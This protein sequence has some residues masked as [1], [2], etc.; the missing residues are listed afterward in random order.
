MTRRE[1]IQ[2]IR[3]SISPRYIRSVLMDLSVFHRQVASDQIVA[4][5]EKAAALMEEV[6]LKTNLYSFTNVEDYCLK[7]PN[8]MAWSFWQAK[9]GWCEVVGEEGRK[10]ADY[11]SDPLS[12]LRESIS[13]D[14]RNEP[15][16]VIYMDRGTEEENYADMDF[17]GKVVFMKNQGDMAVNV[18]S[19]LSWAVKK[20]GA[21]G[22]I[23]SVVGT[24]PDIRG[25]W[26][27]YD[28][29]AWARA[30]PG[31]F[32]FGITP[33][34]GDRLERTYYEKQKK[35]EK[36][37]IRCFVDSEADPVGTMA[38]A[39]ATIEG[40][41]PEEEVVIFAH[42]CHPRPSVNDNLSGCSA[43]LSAMYALNELI[44]RGILPQP[45]RSIR[46]IVGPEMRG[47]LAEI[48]RKGR[49]NTR[50][51]FNMDMVGTD[52]GNPGAGAVFLSD[53]P[54]AT[55]NI[56]NDV[57]SFCLEEVMKDVHN[58][59]VDWLCT[60]NLTQT[61]FSADSDQDMWND[62][63]LDSPCAYMGQY[64]DPYFHS[65]S[66]DISVIDPTL[67]ARSASV[68]AAFAYIIATLEVDDLPLFMAKGC[69]N[70]TRS[71][72]REEYNGDKAYYATIASH[73]RDYYLGCCD[74]YAGYFDGE[75]KARAEELISAQK[76]NISTVIG[77]VANSILGC[78][79][80]LDDYPCDG[81]DLPEKYQY[82][83][84]RHFIGRIWDLPGFAA[85]VEGGTELL[86][87]YNM[88]HRGFNVNRCD[89]TS[90]F[91]ADGKRTLAECIARTCIDRKESRREEMAE[92]LHDYFQLLVKLGLVTIK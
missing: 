10:I 72:V 6:G 82:V 46:G 92:T 16:E 1:Q 32:A 7:T 88:K 24:V 43:V 47:S 49:K 22:Y 15:I 89:A 81:S 12:I 37:Y 60:H 56:T 48:Y 29:I 57:A 21:I 86:R 73:L 55:P 90:I 64:P 42:L 53:A 75:D 31:T 30:F 23:T 50:A 3:N 26:N 67:I 20:R 79:V 52:Q 85:R 44:T 8:D 54:R 71:I 69:E 45:K 34:E 83:P 36:L 91:Y 39:E 84:E 58:C 61:A 2:K 41:N 25:S 18:G 4:S 63:V 33:R 19:Y 59:G 68:A 11:R 66:D 65:S 27:L 62:P 9:A 17:T 87:E 40:T 51:V 35:G 78:R 28:T 5:A 77:A 70:M 76:E 14:Y 13:C 80:N 74:K 38:N